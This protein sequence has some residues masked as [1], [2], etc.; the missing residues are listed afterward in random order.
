MFTIIDGARE[1]TIVRKCSDGRASR[2]LNAVKYL[3]TDMTK[4]QDF[5]IKVQSEDPKKKDEPESENPG[6]TSKP[7]KDAKKEGD[8]EELVRISPLKKPRE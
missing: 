4:A 1:L 8:G 5:S 7:T 6:S 2:T 3:P